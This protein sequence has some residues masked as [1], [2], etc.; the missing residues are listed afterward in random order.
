MHKVPV[1]GSD[2]IG[3][4]VYVHLDPSLIVRQISQILEPT[5]NRHGFGCGD[6]L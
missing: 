3:S 4:L 2:R 5:E 6:L 1:P